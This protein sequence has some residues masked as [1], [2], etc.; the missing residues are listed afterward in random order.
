MRYIVT[1][2]LVVF[3]AGL[4][5]AASP[6][7]SSINELM[8]AMQLE[9]LLNQALK[10]MDEG[11]S[12]GMEQGL[13]KSIQGQELNPAQ[14]AAVEK[15]RTKFQS[16]VK[17]ELAFS[18]VKDIYQQSYRETFT[19][20]EV[21]AITAFYKSP[22]GRAITEKYPTAMQKANNLMQARIGP[23]T[24]KLQTMLDEFVRQLATT[25]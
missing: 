13:Q 16:T 2:L 14:K 10:Q 24:N 3:C 5:Q 21:D 23:L 6:S 11:M 15:F 18:K 22:A 25:K 20:E 1:F 12:K 9:A 4:T 7:D 8:K 17:D 19:Q